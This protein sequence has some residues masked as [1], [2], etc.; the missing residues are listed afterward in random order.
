[1]QASDQQLKIALAQINLKVGDIR[2]NTASILKSIAEAK[3]LCADL[4]IFP[5]LTIIGY[6]PED[7]L[8]RKGLYAQVEH[9]I[10]QILANTSGIDVILGL[11][12][13]IDGKTYNSAAYI[14]DGKILDVY[15]KWALPNYSVF[16]EK[17]YFHSGEKACVV[18][19]KGINLGLTI[20]EDIWESEPTKAAVT[21]GAQIII[22]INASPFHHGKYLNRE[23]SVAKR[24]KENGVSVVYLNLV[25]GQDELVFDGGSFVMNAKAEITTRLAA[26]Q[27]QLEVIEIDTN[28]LAPKPSTI[29]PHPQK[30]EAIY[31]ALVL[32]VRDYVGKNGFKGVVIGL[33]GGI[34]SALTLVVA[35][36]ALGVENVEAVMLPTRYTSEISLTDAE[37]MAQGLSV[38]YKVIPIESAFETFLS[39]LAPEFEGRPFDAT[40]ENIQARIRGLILMAISNKKGAMVLTT[41]N[42]SEMAVGYSTLY[43]D[44]AG[45]FDV[46]KD[47][48]KTL[49]FELSRYCNRDTEIIP[50]RII[51]RPPSAELREDQTDQDSLPDYE[52]LD[53]ILEL[54]IE[55]EISIDEIVAQGFDEKVVCKVTR[56]VD[57]NEYKRRQAPPGVRITPK[58]FGRD[59]RYPITSGF[60]DKIIR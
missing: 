32:G 53:A 41:G 42:K 22:N 60:I 13:L 19:L 14:R 50:T 26:Y 8:Y 28:T 35:I 45:G 49:V 46:L 44:M 34:D 31:Q 59:R 55:Q 11:P 56:M 47:V 25:G 15:D 24:V 30:L 21:R 7:L 16:D 27:Q 4:I 43:G 48:P 23:A 37:L 58:A 20:C 39:M 1:M 40:E 52:I 57:I 10:D 33:S 51:E 5:E 6:P 17:R 38:N 2:G 36:D 9:A 12:R 18:E 29:A 54:Y 3:L